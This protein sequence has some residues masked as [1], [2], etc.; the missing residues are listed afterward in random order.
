[1]TRVFAS[2]GH[3]IAD[4]ATERRIFV[5]YSAIPE[6]VEA[7]LSLSAEDQNFWTHPGIDPLAILH[8]PRCST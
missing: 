6:V 4:F 8:V 3:L 2:D 1:M 7:G 5:P